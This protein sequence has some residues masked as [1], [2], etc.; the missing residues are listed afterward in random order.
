MHHIEIAL[1][2]DGWLAPATVEQCNCCWHAVFW[3]TQGIDERL[4]GLSGVLARKG[5]DAL[6]SAARISGLA[7]LEGCAGARQAR[8]RPALWAARS[9]H[10]IHTRR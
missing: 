9:L 7:G 2:G 8:L 3:R 1:D 5:F 10:P 6:G 4:E